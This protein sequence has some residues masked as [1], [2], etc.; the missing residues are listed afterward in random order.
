MICKVCNK[1]LV[2]LNQQALTNPHEYECPSMIENKSHYKIIKYSEI[3]WYETLRIRINNSVY[4]IESDFRFNEFTVHLNDHKQILYIK[5][6]LDLNIFTKLNNK[7]F[8]NKIN[9]LKNFS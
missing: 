5:K 6:Y 9:M 3:D 8:L 2:A 1:P 4:K 7:E